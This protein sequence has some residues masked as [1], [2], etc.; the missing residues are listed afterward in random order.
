MATKEEL[1]KGLN[2]D[3]AA[4]W[5]TIKRY[6]YQGSKCFGPRGAELRKIF[7][8]E[9][10]DEIGHATFLSD[11][12]VD[13]GGEPTTEAKSFEKPDDLKEMLKLDI[14]MELDDV[15]NYMAHAKMAEELGEVALRFKLEEMAADEDG[16]A[17]EL[18]RLLKGL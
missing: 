16:H 6:T 10:Q 8:A 3:L 15:E 18:A 14:Q 9:T 4:E 13:L 7:N 5:G 1:I 12:I 2:K 17:R 11:A